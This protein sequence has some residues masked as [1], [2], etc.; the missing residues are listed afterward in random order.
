MQVSSHSLAAQFLLTPDYFLRADADDV[1][2]FP[3]PTFLEDCLIVGGMLGFPSEVL[4][5]IKVC[6]DRQAW[7]IVL[8]LIG[9]AW[10]IPGVKLVFSGEAKPIS[11]V[12]M[13]GRP[14]ARFSPLRST[15]K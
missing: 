9:A 1:A 11:G 8:E 6:V 15:G 7:L 2:R 12:E 5:H 4:Q 10:L 13:Y 3:A 14:E